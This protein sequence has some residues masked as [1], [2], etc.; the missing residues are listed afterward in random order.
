MVRFSNKHGHSPQPGDRRRY[1]S[2][3]FIPFLARSMRI[4]F[5]SLFAILALLIGSRVRSAGTASEDVRTERTVK[6]PVEPTGK[7]AF[8]CRMLDND[9][10]QLARASL[11]FTKIELQ[12]WGPPDLLTLEGGANAKITLTRDGIATYHG[13]SGVDRIGKFSGE[14]NVRDYGRVCLLLERLG[15]TEEGQAFGREFN[16]SHPVIHQLSI[17]LPDTKEPKV[18]RNDLNFGDY[19]FWMVQTIIEKLADDVEWSREDK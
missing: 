8:I 11:P 16:V 6:I 3:G 17:Y 10:E 9:E 7:Y 5:T 2:I 4:L 14:L 13:L 19:R 15:V 1:L 18:Y 12:V